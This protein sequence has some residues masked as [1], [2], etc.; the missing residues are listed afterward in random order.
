MICRF[1]VNSEQGFTMN[2]KRIL[3]TYATRQVDSNLFMAGTIFKG[4][5]LCGYKVNMVFCGP[6]GVYET[7]YG[8][9]AECFG[10]VWHLPLPDSY[11][12]RFCNGKACLRLFYSFLR[13]FVLDVICRPYSRNKLRR[14]LAEGDEYDCVLSF[15][16]PYVSGSL[17]VDV[18]AIYGKKS[19]VELI[20]FWTDP[21]SIGGISRISD[22]PLRRMAHVF[23]EYRLLKVADRVIFNFPLLCELEK[24]LHPRFACKMEWTDVGYVEHE[25]DDFVPNNSRVRVGLF[26][27]YQRKV[28]NIEP[29]LEAVRKLPD[30]DF[31][32]RGDSDV[33]VDSATYP[34]L[35]VKPGRQ[36]V[37]GIEVLE[38]NCD[39]L[40]SLNAHS[41]IMPPGKTFYYAS[42]AKPIVY[43]ADGEM[44]DYLMEY[45]VGLGRYIVCR[46]NS[47]SI[48]DGI[49]RAVASMADFQCSIPDRMRLDVIARKIVG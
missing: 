16:P 8:R 40:V 39:I 18:Q 2:R 27:A 3:C 4:L 22:I 33:V 46:N 21:L 44:Q 45:M 6:D 42:Y 31:V 37:A 36:P 47:D 5:N 10:N 30:F 49:K 19:K 23:A 43:I 11:I 38:A 9:Y 17:G 28:R 41:G 35:D 15:V 25:A 32:L 24:E 29:F 1:L 20:Q 34:N 26:G 14:L 7:F 48:V 13:H 12:A